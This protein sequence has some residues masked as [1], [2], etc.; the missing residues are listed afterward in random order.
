MSTALF[1]R[2]HIKKKRKEKNFLISFVLLSLE[3]TV[4]L[5]AQV[6]TEELPTRTTFQSDLCFSESKKKN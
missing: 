4:F 2:A 5:T 3:S 6:L 1:Y